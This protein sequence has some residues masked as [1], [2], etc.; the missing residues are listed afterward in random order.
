MNVYLI[1]TPNGDIYHR[2]DEFIMDDIHDHMDQGECRV[3]AWGREIDLDDHRAPLF[4]LEGNA[5]IKSWIT[6]R[7]EK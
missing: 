1:F 2:T 4:T 7:V 3:K 6:Q 5:S